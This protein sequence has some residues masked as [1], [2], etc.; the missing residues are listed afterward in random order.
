MNLSPK[1]QALL[2]RSLLGLVLVEVPIISAQLQQPTFDYRL[3]AVGLLGAAAGYLEKNVTFHLTP[4]SYAPATPV[5]IGPS[6]PPSL[7]VQPT[8]PPAA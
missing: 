8:P 3:L 2:W 4:D 6:E 7:P 1:T 5:V